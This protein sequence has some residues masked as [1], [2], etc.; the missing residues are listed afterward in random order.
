MIYNAK[1]LYAPFAALLQ[2]S[3]NPILVKAALL[4]SRLQHLKN[5]VHPVSRMG[6]PHNKL[7]VR[8][9]DQSPSSTLQP[10]QRI[11]P[12]LQM[13]MK[14]Y[15]HTNVPPENIRRKLLHTFMV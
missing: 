13:K 8:C 4:H 6:F 10:L 9:V 12:F 2:I 7:I 5:L 15:L 14:I 11:R 1:T 3:L